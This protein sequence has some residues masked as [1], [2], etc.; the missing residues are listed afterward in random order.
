MR[1][2][3][4]ASNPVGP[5]QSTAIRQPLRQ[6]P[7]LADRRNE[8]SRAGHRPKG[9]IRQI[10]QPRHM[11]ICQHRS[12][13]PLRYAALHCRMYICVS[14]A[15]PALFRYTL[16]KR[17]AR[18][19]LM[20]LNEPDFVND[21]L[22][23]LI[24]AST[25]S[26]QLFID[27]IALILAE[28]NPLYV[29]VYSPD[30]T[31]PDTLHLIASTDEINTPR[32]YHPGP[33]LTERSYILS[34]SRLVIAFNTNTAGPFT[35][36][37]PQAVLSMQYAQILSLKRQNIR[38]LLIY[39]SYRS[40]DINSFA[41][42]AVRA[43]AENAVF[44]QEISLFLRDKQERLFLSSST[45]EV[46]GIEKK[47]IFYPITERSPLSTAVTQE[48]PV[49]ESPDTGFTVAPFDRNIGHLQHLYIRGFWPVSLSLAAQEDPSVAGIPPIGTIRI[50]NLS[51]R[52]V[53]GRWPSAFTQYDNS[54]IQYISEITFG[55]LQPYFQAQDTVNIVA[56]L[57]HGI[58]ASIDA[59]MK[60]CDQVNAKL[61]QRGSDGRSDGLLNFS[62][63]D[64]VATTRVLDE[65][66]IDLSE[67]ENFLGDLHFQFS[68]TQQSHYSVRTVKS[69]HSS[70]LM[71]L[72][73]LAPAIAAVNSRDT[74][75]ISN[76][77]DS[78]S[79]LLPPVKA[80][81]EALLSVFRNLVE[82]SIKYT[83]RER[84][85]RIVFSFS[86]DDRYVY[87]DVTDDGIGISEQDRPQLFVEGFRSVHARTIGSNRGA[88]LG[89]AY[90]QHVMRGIGG[91]LTNCP[92]DLGAR[93]RVKIRRAL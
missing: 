30:L 31:R 82:N 37:L 26:F 68:K 59:A 93:F 21:N 81:P 7:A 43:L 86:T 52:G 80:D 2:Q 79:L 12:H 47:D 63:D 20:A 49:I 34:D 73:R 23:R 78:D 41:H 36:E 65:V 9:T 72:L 46:H 87:V 17:R 40:R 4:G 58:G 76:F 61:F 70:V 11:P 92:S 45:S 1:V 88:G 55:I 38:R 69:L 91:D 10:G 3:P 84:A 51:R 14:L 83:S 5:C 16:Q 39:Q 67:L 15:A 27:D 32:I 77:K 8:T 66:Y 53:T 6:R 85:A 25:Q 18:G 71:P 64:P 62:F 75:Q 22:S 24:T 90:S 54:L 28:H 35:P 13:C 42:R 44:C 29:A 89:L 33:S 60:F 57:T 50:T 74:P 48:A 19:A 56:R